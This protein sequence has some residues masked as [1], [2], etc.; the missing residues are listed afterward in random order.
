MGWGH[1]KLLAEG[2][3]W[4]RGHTRGRRE[5]AASASEVAGGDLEGEGRRLGPNPIDL[6]CH[7][8]VKSISSRY[9]KLQPAN[10]RMQAE[11]NAICRPKKAR[12]EY[13][14]MQFAHA[15]S[16]PRGRQQTCILI[17]KSMFLHISTQIF[18]I[19][20]FKCII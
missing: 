18:D 12:A 17:C 5:A 10:T 11:K 9:A 13:A 1:K 20:H 8:T 6:N 3:G 16:A 19:V 14:V 4:R 2:G 15:G 7:P